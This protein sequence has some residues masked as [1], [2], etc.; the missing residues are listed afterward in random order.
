MPVIAVAVVETF[1][2]CATVL[3]ADSAAKAAQVTLVEMRLGQGLGGKA[4]FTMTGELD[5]VEAAA[6]AA[7]AAIESGLLVGIELI[8][9]PHA[10]LRAKLIW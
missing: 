6:D 3:A 7:R 5:A 4:Y 1:T 8:A 2:I 9:A 10:D